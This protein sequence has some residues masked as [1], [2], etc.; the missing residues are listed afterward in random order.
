[1]EMSEEQIKQLE[2]FEDVSKQLK[3]IRVMVDREEKMLERQLYMY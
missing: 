1:M 3:D 2:L